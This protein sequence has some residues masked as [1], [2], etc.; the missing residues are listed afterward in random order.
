MCGEW[1][2]IRSL[3]VSATGRTVLSN[4]QM[5]KSKSLLSRLRVNLHIW[6]EILPHWSKVSLLIY[7]IHNCLTR[8][9]I[10]F[11]LF[12]PH[13]A[14]LFSRMKLRVCHMTNVM[15][16]QL[17]KN[18]W[19]LLANIAIQCKILSV[20]V[21]SFFIFLL[22]QFSSWSRIVTSFIENTCGVYS[23]CVHLWLI[24]V[25]DT[26]YVLYLLCQ[27][28]WLFPLCRSHYAHWTS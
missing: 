22:C 4:T 16:N 21:I 25:V 2:S 23:D 18:W 27:V 3:L 12:R 20:K 28:F 6:E 7:I 8:N 14:V 5:N 9:L 11:F 26:I 13:P 1:R 24:G 15:W 17:E 10:I 19:G